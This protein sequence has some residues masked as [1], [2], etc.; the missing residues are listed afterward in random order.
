MLGAIYSRKHARDRG[1]N[2][3]EEGYDFDDHF[4]KISQNTGREG[5]E[6]YPGSSDSS[7]G[8]DYS[9]PHDL[10]LL[11]LIFAVGVLVEPFPTN[12]S[13]SDS[14]PNGSS[15]HSNSSTTTASRPSP[16]TLGEHYLQLAQAALSLQPVLEKPSIVTIQCLHVMSI[17]NA[18]SGEGTASPSSSTDPGINDL[19]SSTESKTGQNETSMEMT[20]SLITMAAHL[21]QTVRSISVSFPFMLTLLVYRLVY[22]SLIH[23]RSNIH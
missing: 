5:A 15:P 21:S 6:D 16:S 11:F 19:I 10:A 23:L 9:G 1:E 7:S 3:R 13:A 20:W 17:Y 22:V 18:M 4:V 14:P 12:G 2:T 8:G